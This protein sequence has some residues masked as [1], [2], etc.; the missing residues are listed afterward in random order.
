MSTTTL[1]RIIA[2]VACSGTAVAFAAVRV[3]PAWDVVA[4]I[5]LRKFTERFR[6]LTLSEETLRLWLRIWGVAWGLAVYS[7][8]WVADMPPLALFAGFLIYIAPRYIL[9]HLIRRRSHKLRDQLVGS[10]IA[11]ANAV[12]A[13]L[14]IAQGFETV[15]AETSQPLKA[16]LDRIVFEYQHGRPLRESLAAMRDRLNLEEFTLFGLAVEVTLD[17]GGRLN[18]ALDRI[19]ISLREKQRLERKLAA[20]T[21]AGQHAIFMLML[22]PPGFLVALSLFNVEYYNAVFHTLTGQAMLAVTCLLVYLGARW[23]WKI[24][25]FEF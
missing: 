1:L 25:H 13:G 21:A 16:E 3:W 18:E 19:C 4:E 9:D 24:I 10:A 15:A 14:S 5:Q 6:R 20:A 12:K 8:W 22:A 17:R 11:L 2:A 23:A 7:L